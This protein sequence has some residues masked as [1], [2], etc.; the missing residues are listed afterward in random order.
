MPGLA[1]IE[2]IKDM[3]LIFN[4]RVCVFANELIIYNPKRNVGSQDG[5]IPEGTFQ[6]MKKRKQ[7]IVLHRSTPGQSAIVDFETMREDMKRKFIE[8]NG[9]PRAVIATQSQRAFWKKPLS[10]VTMPLSFTQPSIGMM[11]ARSFR[12]PR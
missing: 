4:N 6:T 3:A 7:I 11:V 12:M 5:F 2:K 1:L 10:S 8:L 9:D